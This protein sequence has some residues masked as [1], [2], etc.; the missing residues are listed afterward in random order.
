MRFTSKGAVEYDLSQH[1]KLRNEYLEKRKQLSEFE[2]CLIKKTNEKNCKP[3]YSVKRK[4]ASKYAY[5]GGDEKEEII[6]IR[7]YA[8]LE[9]SLKVIETNIYAMEHFLRVYQSTHADH[10]TDLLPQ[11]YKIVG[12]VNWL[13]H[14]IRTERW[15]KAKQAIKDSHP[16]FDP[17]SLKVTSFDGTM[18]RSRA[19]CIH[20]ESFYIYNVPAIF[21][22]PYEFGSEIL[23]PDFTA[24]YVFTMTDRMIEHLGNWFHSDEYKRNK[25]RQ[26]SVHK[27]DQYAKIGFTPESNLL[28]TFGADENHFDAQAILHKI[29]MLAFPPPS[30]DTIDMLRKL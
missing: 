9:K 13:E 26:D 19:E 20:H 25:Y 24:L 5:V 3:F 18:V 7:K 14:E 6:G 4:G 23:Y 16:I 17:A 29:S 11:T 27:W 1:Y 12:P 22:L 8:Y 2:G 21:E 28:L 30:E 15:L 10:I